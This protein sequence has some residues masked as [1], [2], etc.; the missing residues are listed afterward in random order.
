MVPAISI[1]LYFHRNIFKKV[2]VFQRPKATIENTTIHHES[3]TISP[4]I[5]HH[6]NTPKAKTPLQI[7]HLRIAANAKKKSLNRDQKSARS[8]SVSFRQLYAVS[9]VFVLATI[10]VGLTG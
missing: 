2:E 3:T 4:R 1:A 6:K 8:S 5:Y 9:P 10:G 7:T